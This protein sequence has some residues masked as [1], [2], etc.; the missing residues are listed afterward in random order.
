MLGKSP[1]KVFN[2]SLGC[3]TFGKKACFKSTST[4]HHF[5]YQIWTDHIYVYNIA[6]FI[7]NL[8]STDILLQVYSI[9]YDGVRIYFKDSSNYPHKLVSLFPNEPR[10]VSCA[11]QNPK[12]MTQRKH[13]SMHVFLH[14]TFSAN[15]A[16]RLFSYKST[17]VCY[18]LKYSLGI[19]QNTIPGSILTLHQIP[20]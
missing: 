12:F 17:K 8:P 4:C 19:S 3:H 10:K 9:C 6:F 1:N 11:I 14:I 2:L 7:F 20:K 15:N 18:W 13:V 5:Y 16:T